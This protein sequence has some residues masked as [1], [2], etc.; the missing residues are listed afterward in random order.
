MTVLYARSD[1]TQVTV[2]PSGH[3][4][5]KK[6]KGE[7]TVNCPACEDTLLTLGWARDPRHVEL[8][9][10]EIDAMETEQKEIDRYQTQQVAASARAASAAVRA[11]RS[12]GR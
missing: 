7:F 8:T 12:T 10:D 11:S 3:T 6:G 4:H 9:P 1:V 2:G 5:V